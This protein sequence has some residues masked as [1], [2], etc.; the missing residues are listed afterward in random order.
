MALLIEHCP[1]RWQAINHSQSMALKTDQLSLTYQQLDQL[2][3]QLQA[4]LTNQIDTTNTELIRLICIST[5]TFNLLLLQLVCLRAGWCFCPLNPRFT[6]AEIKQR[7]FILNSEYCWV[8]QDSIHRDLATLTIDFTLSN[9]H[10]SENLEALT[11]NPEQPCNI[12]FTSGSSGFPKAIVHHYKNHFYSALGSQSIISLG[13]GDHNLLSLPLFHIGGY[14]TVMRSIIAGASIHISAAPV[15]YSLLQDRKITHLSLVST[16]LIRLLEDP[17]FNRSQSSIR[18]ILLGGSAFSDH[19]LAALLKRGFDYHLSYGCTEMASQ[20]ATS[21][22]NTRLNLLP[23][24]QV[25]IEKGEIY[26]RGETRF[27]GYFK[28]NK[29]LKLD[30]EQWIAIGDIGQMN[31][32]TLAILGR[33][34]R[35]FISGGENIKPEEIERICLQHQAVKEV[36]V[37]PINDPTYD[38]RVALFVSFFDKK[39]LTFEQ[40]TKQLHQYLKTQLTSFKL[41]NHYLPWPTLTTNQ[42]LKIPKQIFQDRLKEQGLI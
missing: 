10:Y 26:L 35:Q 6:E 40:H 23:Y 5:N 30:P 7:Y 18:H 36:Y 41:P 29:L 14:A 16:Q 21:I 24:R 12:I 9:N 19:L 3:T 34:D 22:N 4:Q 20:V 31:N 15:T 13:L 2:L 27:L 37:C 8:S 38:Q 28:E 32:N 1:I 11:I 25:K 33:K 17:N 39:E 42:V